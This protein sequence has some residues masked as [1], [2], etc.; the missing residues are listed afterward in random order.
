MRA[1]ASATRGCAWLFT[2]RLRVM[3]SV[4]KKKLDFGHVP[5][6]LLLSAQRGEAEEF[7]E[8][9]SKDPGV[10][11]STARH[12]VCLPAARRSVG[13]D[14]DRVAV[15]G[16]GNQVPHLRGVEDVGV[17]LLGTKDAVEPPSLRCVRVIVP[18]PDLIERALRQVDP[19]V[20]ARGRLA[21]R[22]RAAAARDLSRS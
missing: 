1:L 22:R 19:R 12:R 21:L 8:G 2:P 13:E 6:L 7:C 11:I 20:V 17:G 16:A 3:T 15:Q 18:Q 4:Q 10:L 14:A 9:P 5:P